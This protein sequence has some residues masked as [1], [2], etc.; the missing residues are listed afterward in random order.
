MQEIWKDIEGYEGLYKVS[1][2]GR[3]KSLGNKSN[4]KSEIILRQSNVLG[5][6][7]V[8]L[9][10]DS[11]SKMFKVHRLVAQAFIPNPNNRPQVNHKNGIKTDNCIDNLEWCD[12]KQNMQ[13]AVKYG[14]AK[15]LKGKD[16]PR[17]KKIYQIDVL[18]NKVVNVFCGLREMERETGFSRSNVVNSTKRKEGT[19]YGWKW[20]I[21]NIL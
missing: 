12:A 17:S 10:R 21:N 6:S 19:A 2:L 13:H 1:N 11:K 18:T 8:S 14:L 4:H 5:Y 9:L 16:N 7:M 15:Q 20:S 3:V